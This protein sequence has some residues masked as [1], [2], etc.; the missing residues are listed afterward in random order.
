[1]NKLYSDQ[2]PV[3]NKPDMKKH[4]RSRTRQQKT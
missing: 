4:R 1:M 2:E 3:K